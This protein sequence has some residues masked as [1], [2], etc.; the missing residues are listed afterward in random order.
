MKL[1]VNELTP[2]LLEAA[3]KNKGGME[4]KPF[5]IKGHMW[6]FINCLIENPSF[7]SQTKENMTLKTKSFGSTCSLTDKFIKQALSEIM[8]QDAV[9]VDESGKRLSIERIYQKKTPLEHVLLRPDTYVGSVEESTQPMWVYDDDKKAIVNKT[10]TFVPG[11]YK[12]FDEIL[13]M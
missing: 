5:H 10:I 7:D 12:I 3:K 1:V 4:L 8:D 9:E 13:G 2:K 11:L 6:V